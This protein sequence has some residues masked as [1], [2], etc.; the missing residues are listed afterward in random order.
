[1]THSSVEMSGSGAADPGPDSTVLRTPSSANFTPV[2]RGGRDD[3]PSAQIG[4][5][6]LRRK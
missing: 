2:L 5:E 6:R 1:M 4:E 3:G